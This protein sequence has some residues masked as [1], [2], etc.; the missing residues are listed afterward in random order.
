MTVAGPALSRTHM[1][2]IPSYNPGPYALRTVRAARAVWAPVWVVVDGSTDG[3]AAKMLAEAQQD[4]GLRV[5]VLERNHGKGGAVLAGLLAAQA[6]GFTHALAC[7]ADGQHPAAEIPAFMAASMAAPEAMVLGVPVFDATAPAFR[8][9]GR[10]VSNWWAGVE[11]GG[12]CR[13]SLFGFRVYPIA[14]LASI[15]EGTRWMRRFDFDAEAAVRLELAWRPHDQ[16]TG[17]CRVFLESGRRRLTFSLWPGQRA[18]DLD[19]Y[20]SDAGIPGL[21]C[22][23]K[24]RPRGCRRLASHSASRAG[25]WPPARREALRAQPRVHE[26]F[27]P[28]ARH[29]S[30]ARRPAAR[31]ASSRARAASALPLMPSSARRVQDASAQSGGCQRRLQQWAAQAHGRAEKLRRA[32]RKI[33]Q[34]VLRRVDLAPQRGRRQAREADEMAVGVVLHR[35]AAS[36]DGAHKAG[37]RPRCRADAEE[38][39]FRTVFVEYV[40]HRGCHRRIGTVVERQCQLGP[41]GGGQPVQIGTQ[42]PAARR[43]PGSGQRRMVQNHGAQGPTPQQRMRDADPRRGDVQQDGGTHHRGHAAVSRWTGRTPSATVT[44]R[45][46]GNRI[47]LWGLSPA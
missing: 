9:K 40:E 34:G 45:S 36:C 35:V 31:P 38:G 3:S 11:T 24:E 2:L 6:E 27:W 4:T 1:V 41:S 21:A 13:D 46:G 26:P 7:D 16:S 28:R 29:A 23:A 22:M 19:A 39:R 12:E 47:T 20:P 5:I 10:R 32:A 42:Q 44:L 33:G 17:A 30:A 15:M 37:M 14:P 8:V 25:G 43:H 18:A